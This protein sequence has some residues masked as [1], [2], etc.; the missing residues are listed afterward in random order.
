M[1]VSVY[2][3]LKTIKKNSINL[4]SVQAEVLN[5]VVLKENDN[6]KETGREHFT[7]SKGWFHHFRTGHELII[8]EWAWW[9]GWGPKG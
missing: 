4:P 7:A 2:F 1:N 8:V 3:G 5:L 9:H 6:N